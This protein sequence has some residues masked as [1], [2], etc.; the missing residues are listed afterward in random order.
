MSLPIP[1]MNGEGLLE[2]PFC[3]VASAY[4]DFCHRRSMYSVR[5]GDCDCATGEWLHQEG[6]VKLWNT[7]AG[8]LFTEQDYKDMNDERKNDYG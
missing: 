4:N 6:A 3:G 5:C 1:M 2:C 7:R 8:H